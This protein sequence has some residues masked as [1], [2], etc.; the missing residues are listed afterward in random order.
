MFI[1]P[2]KVIFFIDRFLVRIEKYF[3][4][5]SLLVLLIFAFLQVV[6]RNFFDSGINWADVFNRLLVLWVGVFA[7]TIAAKQDRHLSLEV[8]TKFLP[9]KVRPLVNIFVYIFVVV[10]A[11]LLTRASCLF[12]QDQLMFE[13][14]D[15]LFKGVPKAYFSVIF[16]I[17]F[18]L[19]TWRYLVKILEVI[20]NFAGGD[21]E[22]PQQEEQGEISVSVKIKLK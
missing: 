1:N 8:L 22:Y 19:I 9:D 16:P 4:L 21:K 3:L 15:L 20:Y 11:V 7:A 12:F 2:F 5:V 14:G 10:V 13:S 18:G 17:G 6:L